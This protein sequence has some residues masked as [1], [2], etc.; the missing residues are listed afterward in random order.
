MEVKEIP[1]S[2]IIRS[3]CRMRLEYD[4]EYEE[5][6]ASIRKSGVQVPI[7]VKKVKGDYRLFAGMTT[8]L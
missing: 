5:L 7:R 3:L 2:M 1:I 4:Y 8:V 6:L